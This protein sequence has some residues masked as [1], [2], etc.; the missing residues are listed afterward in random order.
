MVDQ[1]ALGTAQHSAR[2]TQHSLRVGLVGYGAIGRPLAAAIAAGAAG[3]IELAAVLVRDPTRHGAV[4]GGCLLTGDPDAFLR[5]P[6]ELVVE[7]GGHDAVRQHGEAVL[8]AGRDLMVVSVGAFADEGLLGRL[9][10]AARATGRQVL[11]PSGAMAGLDA[12]GAAA[13]GGLDEVSITTRKPP[14]AWIGT[15]GEAQAVAASEPVLL[16]DGPARAGVPRF[17]Q[18][19]NVAAALA[20]AGVGLDATTMRVYADPTVSRNTHEV[21]ARGAFGELHLVLQNV[22]SPDNPKTG[23]I[24]AMSVLKALRNRAAPLVVGL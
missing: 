12:I 8:G 14:P 3:S 16:Y 13:V 7:A 17:P 11:V 15:E 6:M 9:Q 22:P 4:P 5:A 2:S 10:A 19:V 23:R 18:N 1:P 24:V 20:L 21:H